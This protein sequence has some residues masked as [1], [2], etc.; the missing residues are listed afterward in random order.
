MDFLSNLSLHE[1]KLIVGIDFGT[2]FS[3]IAWAETRRVDHHSVIETW[4]SRLGVS[5]GISSAKAP[6]ELRYTPQ[7]T[8]WGFQ[9]PATAD[10]H[11]WFKVGIDNKKL[12]LANDQQ[13]SPEQLATDYLSQLY[14]HLMY[15]LEQQVGAAILRTIPLEFCIT[16]PAIWSEASK[17]K[18]LKACEKAGI[19]SASK[20]LLVSEPEAAAIYALKG[21]DPHG[22]NI[23]DSFVL[24]DAGGGTVDLISYTIT[25]LHPILKV[26]EA[27]EGTGGMCGSTFLNRR[28]G[29]F[30]TTRLG[31]EP[32][33][34]SEILAEAMERF[35]SV[36]KKQYAPTTASD[37]GYSIMVPGLANNPKLGIRRGRFTVK[38]AEMKSI[39][40]PIII[41]VIDLV[42]DQIKASNK[43]IRAVLLVGGF[44]QNNY[45]KERLRGSLGGVEVLQ[46]PNA[47]T[48]IVRGAVL[49]GLSNAN[50]KLAAV[51]VVSRAARKHYGTEL[52]VDFVP[53]VHNQSQK[54]WSD[55]YK[56]FRVNAMKWFIHK[57]DAVEENKPHSV[58]FVSDHLVSDGTP[59]KVQLTIY[60][61]SVGVK[62]PVHR[63]ENVQPLVSLSADLS[64]LSEATLKSTITKRSDGKSYYSINGSVEAT[65]YSASTK[66]VLLSHGKRYDTVTAE[67]V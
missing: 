42:R 23:G 14:G 10:R 28:F 2:T 29:E 51:S 40:E 43:E 67:Y 15:T 41:K 37:D 60:A 63:S 49:M 19:K 58:N 16:V 1:R 56:C 22:L 45:L 35:D 54:F 8:E 4:P 11:Q 21:L 26:K 50:S 7:G 34:D 39:F 46:P 38:P 44:G 30:L 33:W 31:K 53:G 52:V 48:A 20:I 12:A 6:T 66:Y 65:F 25:Q 57:R 13:K 59:K 55:I 62:A 18:T 64:H 36:I 3:G 61:C 5:E 32:G 27:A 24:C 9:I 17:E 47:W